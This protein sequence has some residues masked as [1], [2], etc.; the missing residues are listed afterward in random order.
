MVPPLG[1][2]FVFESDLSVEQELDLIPALTVEDATTSTNITI[3]VDV[4][5]WFRDGLGGLIDPA[6][7][8]EGLVN[9]ELVEDNIE[10]AMEAFED[11][12]EDG[13]EG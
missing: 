10:N 2:D 13:S 1:Q 6:T 4:D 7:A 11:E 12:D 9:E 3:F 5:S 8:N